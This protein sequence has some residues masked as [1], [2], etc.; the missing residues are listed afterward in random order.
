MNNQ[1]LDVVAVVPAAGKGT[2][3]APL[4]CSKEIFPIGFRYD[5]RSGERRPEVAS[6]HLFEKFRLA[7]ITTAYVI[8]RQGKWD[9][10]TYY[11]DGQLVEMNIAYIVIS[12]SIGPPDTLD[13]AYAFVADR[14]VAFGFPDI[15]FGPNDVF[16]RLLRRQRER[17]P[18]VVLGLYPA[19]DMPAD[20]V[21]IDGDG[22]IQEMVLKPVSSSLRYT[23]A[24]AV[25]TRTFTEFMHAF[26]KS[27]RENS[28]GR[29]VDYDKI[30]PSGDLPVGA[31]LKAA[32]EGGLRVEGVTFPDQTCLDIGTPERLFEAMRSAACK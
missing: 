17:G 23:W 28:D 24:C 29:R 14:L 16:A 5:D 30:D 18:D 22:R 9:I 32:V 3:I 6:H 8:L 13:R 27:E 10:P 26:I 1:P 15:L 4:P 19:I 21:E 11:G 25:W 20:L 7:G 12:E 31:A 2:R